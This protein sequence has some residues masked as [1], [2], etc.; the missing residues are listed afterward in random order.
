ML[1]VTTDKHE[2]SRGL[3]A[4]ADLLVSQP[5]PMKFNKSRHFGP[6][7][8]SGCSHLQMLAYTEDL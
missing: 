1:K 4:T 8:Q 6:T 3:S 7:Q 5:G 2:A